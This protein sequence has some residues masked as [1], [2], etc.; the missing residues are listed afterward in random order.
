VRV[1]EPTDGLAFDSMGNPYLRSLEESA[2]KLLRPGGA[3]EIFAASA[4][5]L[6][7]DTIAMSRDG[8]L[9]VSASQF[10]LMPA[11]NQNVDKRMPPHNVFRLRVFRN[12]IGQHRHAEGARRF[13]ERITRSRLMRGDK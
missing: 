8:Y 7:P 1:T 9:L 2:V 3:Y 12:E 6:W 5:F 11:F 13:C 4:E 10:H